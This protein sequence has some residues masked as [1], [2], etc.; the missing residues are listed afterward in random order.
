MD[1]D[2]AAVGAS[3][4]FLGTRASLM[5]DVVFLAMFAVLPL[6]AWSIYEVKYRG[7]YQLHKVVQLLLGGVLLLAVTAFEIDMRFVTN[8]EQ[9]A[10]ASPYYTAGPWNAVWWSLA[11][12]LCFAIPTAL[13]WIAVIFRAMRHFPSPPHPG[14]HSRSHLFWARLAA[15]GMFLTAVTG[16]LFYWLAFVA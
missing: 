10:E 12:H 4:G 15:A 8:W 5:L 16:W 2:P 14:P 11:V 3:G 7:R 9:L 13:L 6:L 1:I